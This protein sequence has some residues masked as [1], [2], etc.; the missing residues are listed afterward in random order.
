MG[1]GIT[2]RWMDCGRQGNAVHVSSLAAHQGHLYAT[3][4]RDD[5]RNSLLHNTGNMADLR[6]YA[7]AINALDVERLASRKSTLP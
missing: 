4:G 6:V 7:S 1:S 5:P 3:S 2:P